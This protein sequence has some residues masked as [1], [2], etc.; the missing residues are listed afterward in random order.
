MAGKETLGSRAVSGAA[1][2]ILTGVGARGLGLVGTVVLTYYLA[3]D[4]IGEVSD[5]SIVTLL[6]TQFSTIGLGQYLVAKPNAGRDVT[7]H[8]VVFH[9]VLGVLA[10]GACLLFVEPLSAWMK[11]PTLARYLPGLTVAVLIDR[12]TLVPERLL[13]REMKFRTIGLGRSAGE[14]TYTLSSVGLAMAG[15]GGMA[16]VYANIVR[17]LLRLVIVASVVPRADWLTPT[18]FSMATTRE[19]LRFG[20]PFSLAA[21]AG[22]ASRK[23]DNVL[24]SSF[25]GTEVVAVYNLAY[26][27]ADV[28]AVQVGEQIGDVLLPSFAHMDHESRKAALVRASGLLGLIVS[29]LAVGLGAIA[30]TLVRAILR[31]EWADVG[32]MLT[33]LSVL[34]VTRPMGWTISAYLQARDRPSVMMYLEVFKIVSLVALMVAL[35]RF[36]PLWACGGV[37]IAFTIHAVA[38]IWLVHRLDGIPFFGLLWRAVPP[39]A[40]CAPMVAAVLGARWWMQRVGL[41][42]RFVD[43]AG[44]LTVGAIAYVASAFVI[45]RSTTRDFLELAGNAIRK[46]RRGRAAAPEPEAAG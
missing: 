38:S 19:L 29:P 25:F 2:T 4:V 7:W 18:R 45:A 6:A 24:I 14:L 40:A 42:Q 35:A 27:V 36:G 26:N 17:S 34:S 44:E 28:P 11:A 8:A 46:R 32:P 31:P 15:L 13:V 5:A 3:R 39:L 37:G 41:D 20:L 9:L 30:P 43:L 10:L 33:V 22:Q 23:I 21:S 16:V 12:V 1:W